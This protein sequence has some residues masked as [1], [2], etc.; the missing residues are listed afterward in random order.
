[1]EAVAR[2]FGTD[3]H[4]CR[5]TGQDVERELDHFIAS[6][7]QPSIDGLN[8]YFVSKF[9]RESGVTV[10]LSGLG[11][12]ELFGGYPSFHQLPRLVL[13]MRV[14]RALPGLISVARVATRSDRLA[15]ARRK[16]YEMLGTDGSIPALYAVR[17]GLFLGDSVARLLTP[18]FMNGLA[19]PEATSEARVLAALPDGRHRVWTTTSWLEMGLYMGNQLLRDTDSMSM[20]H[21]LEVRVPL[22]DYRLVEYVT[23]LPEKFQRSGRVPKS[24]LIQAMAPLLPSEITQRRKMT[25]SFPIAEWMRGSLRSVVEDALYAPSVTM[26]RIL[27]PAATRHV[28]EEFLA[29]RVGWTRPWGLAMLVMWLQ[30]HLFD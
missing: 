29:G 14:G 4:D 28:W 2:R 7:D 30:K 27:D 8:S 18:G 9:T 24:L 26:R 21:S 6:L 16:L 22:I 10:A 1:M 3:H 12:D 15:G 23:S 19:L 5:V 17:R 20:A 25:F 13:A 11:G